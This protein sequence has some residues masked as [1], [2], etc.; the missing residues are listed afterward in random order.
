MTTLAMQ[1]DGRLGPEEEVDEADL[2]RSPF[3][4]G[5]ISVVVVIVTTVIGQ[6][7]PSQADEHR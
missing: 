6:Q 4:D 7:E 3:T 2:L 1:T 5:Y